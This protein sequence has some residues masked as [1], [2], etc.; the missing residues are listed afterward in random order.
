[1]NWTF[2]KNSEVKNEHKNK[3]GKLKTHLFIW[4]FKL[5]RFPYGI[6]MKHKSRLCA[7]G[8][9]QKWVVNYWRTYTPVVNWM[10]VRSLLSISIIH[11][12]P[13]ISIGFFTCLYPSWPWYGCLHGYSFS[14]GNWLKQRIMDHKVKQINWFDLLKTGL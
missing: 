7:H 12:L 5:K 11:E 9:M 1:M 10:S 8:W 4:Y 6:L 2:M 14:N 3:G 13:R